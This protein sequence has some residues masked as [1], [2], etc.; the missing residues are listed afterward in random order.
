M[1]GEVILS[2]GLGRQIVRGEVGIR[3]NPAHERCGKRD[4]R[5]AE[6]TAATESSLHLGVVRLESRLAVGSGQEPVRHRVAVRVQEL[7]S[8][9]EGDFRVGKL[10]FEPLEEG[11]SV[12]R[13]SVVVSKHNVRLV[14]K[15][16]DNSDALDIRFER[17]RAIVLQQHHRLIRHLAGHGAVFGAVELALRDLR[18]RNHVRRVEHAQLYARRKQANHSG[19]HRTL[20]EITLLHGVDKSLGIAGTF[21]VH[22]ANDRNGRGFGLRRPVMV[23]G[24]NIRDCA[25]VGDDISLETPLAAKL[26]LKQELVG[27]SR[28]TVDRVIGAHHRSGLAFHDGG[29]ET[30]LI[31]VEF[32]V[33]AHIHIRKVP[34]RFRAAVHIKVLGCGDHAVVLRIF[35]LHAGNESDAHAAD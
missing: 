35:A 29:A 30:R 18:V 33:P 21:V 12:G 16:P 19:V 27:A 17:K 22:A 2:F 20:G 32:I 8:G 6:T 31:S 9:Y 7:G 34:C 25:A 3:L 28:L 11:N 1:H 14:G 24:E 10:G 23:T 5:T 13:P 26:I 15:R 4:I